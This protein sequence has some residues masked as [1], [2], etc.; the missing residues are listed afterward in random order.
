MA[1]RFFMRHWYDIGGALVIPVLIWAVLGD[2]STV[3]LIL[4][5][6]FAVILIHQFEEYRAPG[7][8]PWVLNEVFQ[9]KGGPVDRYPL[10]QLNGTFINVLAWPFY[11]V[12]VFF[13]E[14]VWLGLAPALFGAPG[15]VMVHGVI[16]NRKLK[17]LYNPGVAA[18]ML[19][20]LP[21][22]VWYL[23]EVYRTDLITGWDWLF[24]LIYIAF[25]VGVIM[26]RLGYG[27]LAPLD[28]KH[29]F[30]DAELDRWDRLRR[31][32]HAGITPLPLHPTETTK[33]G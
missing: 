12:P 9:P 4:L 24:A 8:E 5:L 31:L 1:M 20:H 16:T 3:Q 22:T 18:V 15:Q 2:W 27:V 6:N 13:P 21:L 14:Q 29:P 32:D 25:F 33:L 19:G 30:E 7:G 11:L 26:M 28:S 17:T 23:V 10:N